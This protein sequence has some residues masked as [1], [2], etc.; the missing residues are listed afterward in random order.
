M[1]K[2]PRLT[3]SAKRRRVEIA[4]Q[5]SQYLEEIWRKTIFI[6]E[7]SFE[8]GPKGQVRVRRMVGTRY[9]PENV[10]EKQNSGWSS[11]MCCACFSYAG[12]GPI[13]RSTGNFNSDQYVK[14][15]EDHVMPYS[16]RVFPDMDFYILHDNSRI[17][18]SYQTLAYLVLRFGPERIIAHAPYSPDCNPIENLFGLISRKI[19]K[20]RIIFNNNDL[21]WNELQLQWNQLG[22]DI[23][24]LQNLALSMR[25]RYRA[26]I[27]SNG[28]A[29]R[30]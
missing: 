19:T 1:A 2:K 27:E 24:T 4:E 25:D 14:Y 28:E 5:N 17:H 22:L 6:D 29:I 7:F 10:L 11:I 26:V 21:L 9:D 8:T 13:I 20:K 23:E 30:Y 16:E 12:I 18:T 15:F 3:E